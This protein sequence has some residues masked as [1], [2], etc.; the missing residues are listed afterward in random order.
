MIEFLNKGVPIRIDINLT[1]SLNSPNTF[2]GVFSNRKTSPESAIISQNSFSGTF[3]TTG[4]D[5]TV[6]HALTIVGYA[7]SETDSNVGRFGVVNSQGTESGLSGYGYITY[8]Y[9][10]K[11]STDGGMVARIIAFQ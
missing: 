1:R 9:F 4:E 3:T 7:N 2:F 10:F 6:G 8:D 11:T 5:P